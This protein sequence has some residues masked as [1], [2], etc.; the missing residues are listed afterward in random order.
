MPRDVGLE[1]KH[2]ELDLQQV[3]FA[4][5]ACL[6]TRFR[7]LHRV[8][9]TLEVLARQLQRRF[10]KLNIDELRSNIEGETAF[11]VGNLGPAYG[12]HDPWPPAGGVA[13]SFRAQTDS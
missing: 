13:A 7:D 11:V 6:V 10:G 1:L 8:L 2:L 5:V 9:K 12:R 4:N 3:S